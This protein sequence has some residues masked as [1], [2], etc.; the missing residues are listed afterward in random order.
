MIALIVCVYYRCKPA[1]LRAYDNV[2][3]A[4]QTDVVAVRILFG[5]VLYVCMSVVSLVDARIP[6]FP[7]APR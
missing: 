1:V 4:I 7:A 6:V 5:A 2:S 3:H